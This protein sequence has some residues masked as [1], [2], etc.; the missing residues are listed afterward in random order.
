MK[1]MTL[2]GAA[3]AL[4]MTGAAQSQEVTGE[5]LWEVGL[6]AGVGS[7]PDYPAAEQNHGRAL[8]LPF[9]RYRG[10]IL[11]SDEKGLVRGRFI[12]TPAIEV[13]ISLN[14]SFPAQSDKNTARAGMPDLDWL[15]EI[16]PRVEWT[17][18]RTA[19]DVARVTV[20]LPVRTVWSTDFS[21][22]FKY[23]GIVAQ[24]QVVYRH[25]DIL[26]SAVRL[27]LGL[28]STFGTGELMDMFY[29]VA[30]RYATATRP[31]Y[32][33]NAGYLGSHLRLTAGRA[34]TPWASVYGLLEGRSHHGATNSESPL[35]R[36]DTGVAAGIGL[37][38]RL[39]RSRQ[40]VARD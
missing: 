5:P 37:T 19:G 10:D 13:D 34:V 1:R 39:A 7:L 17:V 28:A 11:R 6:A 30:P 27:R 22:R 8:A 9:L 32:D 29:G 36:R 4:I 25:D 24:P 20:D 21:E 3:L 33:A 35:F 31:A 38:I 15:G 2:T 40:T 14:G 18:A 16:G 23:R 26:G 12:H